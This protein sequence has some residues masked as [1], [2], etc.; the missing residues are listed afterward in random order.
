MRENP[1]KDVLVVMPGDAYKEI[2]AGEAET[3]K[4][5]VQPEGD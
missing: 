3:F 5:V 4:P 1:N 2:K